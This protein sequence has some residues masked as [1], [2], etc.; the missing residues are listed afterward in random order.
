MVPNTGLNILSTSNRAH[1][2]SQELE[3]FL[4]FVMLL[5][6]SLENNL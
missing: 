5:T 2:E 1:E 3:G 6:N 4:F